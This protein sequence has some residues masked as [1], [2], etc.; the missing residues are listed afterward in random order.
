[1]TLEHA[2]ISFSS[3]I[4]TQ[5]AINECESRSGRTWWLMTSWPPLHAIPEEARLKRHLQ[6]PNRGASSVALSSILISAIDSF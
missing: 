1:M 6:V 5:A 4:A 2:S 3:H